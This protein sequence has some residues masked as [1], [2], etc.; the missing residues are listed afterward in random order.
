MRNQ[1]Q[2][3]RRDRRLSLAAAALGI[4]AIA[5]FYLT[6]GCPIRFFTG[7]SCPGCGMSRAAAH[8]ARLD[9]AGAFHY[10]PVIFAMPVFAA[11]FIWSRKRP[12]AKTAVL[13]VFCVLMAGVWLWRML[14]PAFRDVVY[15][16]PRTSAVWRLLLRL[17]EFL[18]R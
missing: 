8:L 9:F 16:A 10:H 17:K 18:H 6:V 12:R 1:E 14:D 4:I 15:F 5:A 11:A 2:N 13:T 7:V 3:A